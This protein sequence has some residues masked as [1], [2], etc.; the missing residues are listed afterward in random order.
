MTNGEPL[1]TTSDFADFSSL[2]VKKVNRK[3]VVTGDFHY[4]KGLSNDQQCSVIFYKKQGGQYKLM[5][6][7]V[8]AQGC[9]DFY[10][11]D[12]YVV[13][14]FENMCEKCPKQKD[15]V[16]P[17]P[18]VSYSGIITVSIKYH[19]LFNFIIKG[20]YRVENMVIDVEKL[21]PYFEGE[22]KAEFQVLQN[23]EILVGYRFYGN[24]IK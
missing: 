8:P 16:C 15:R 1:N 24:I 17:W 5:T 20:K 13:P 11:L 18:P 6:F 21:P 14:D 2:K 22:F 3:H 4:K 12:T 7:R 10:N 9:C 23:N 19:K